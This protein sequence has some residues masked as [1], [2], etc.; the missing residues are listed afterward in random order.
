VLPKS[1]SPKGDEVFYLQDWASAMFLWYAL[2]WSVIE[3][4]H[5]RGIDL[6]GRW[7]ADIADVEDDLRRFR[8]A[9]FHVP[10]NKYHDDRF[11][12][13]MT[14]A[15]NAAK[16]SRISSGF[17]RLF[18]EQYAAASW[19]LV[20]ASRHLEENLDTGLDGDRNNPETEDEG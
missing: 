3:G 6:R 17:G 20:Q 4:F 18:L 7:A 13:V 9:V 8:N 19:G 2:I 15:D 1:E 14:D 5:A 12:G 11:F 10:R 16:I